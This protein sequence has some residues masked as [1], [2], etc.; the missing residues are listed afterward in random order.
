MKF[1]SNFC[2]DLSRSKF[3]LKGE[4]SIKN[5]LDFSRSRDQL[6]PGSFPIS[7]PEHARSQVRVGTGMLLGTRLDLSR[8]QEVRAWE[9]G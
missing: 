3:H 8:P 2:P 9:R 4:R 7:F 5:L 6:L 1:L